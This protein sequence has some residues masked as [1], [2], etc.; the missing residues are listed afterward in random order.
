MSDITNAQIQIHN[1][2]HLLGIVILYYDHSITFDEEYR[3]IWQNKWSGASWLFFVNRYFAFAANIAVNVGNFA[4]F[5]SDQRCVCRPKSIPCRLYEAVAKLMNSSCSCSDFS[6]YRQIVLIVSQVIVCI[7]L[8]LR[9]YALYGRDKRIMYLILSV[10]FTLASLACWSV[11]GQKS[12][13]SIVDGCHIASSRLSAIH[14]AVAW[15][16]LFAYD[17]MIV[18][19]TLLKTYKERIRLRPEHRRDLVSLIV[20]DGAI[21]FAVM[22]CANFANTITFYLLAPALRGVLSTFASA[23]SVTMMSRLMLNLHSTAAEH[24]TNYTTTTQPTTMSTTSMLFSSRFALPTSQQDTVV[25]EGAPAEA[26]QIE[27]IE[28]IQ[29]PSPQEDSVQTPRTLV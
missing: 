6:L 12:D 9:T 20:R 26:L 11:V 2:L 10:G 16:A 29:V 7:N 28:L 15:E 8:L 17:I 27:E 22:A 18:T 24:R 3:Y 13:V 14:I 5:R 21:Y 23:V 19:L 4:Q 1:A 25:E